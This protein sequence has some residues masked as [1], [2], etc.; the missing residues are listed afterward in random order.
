MGYQTKAL[1]RRWQHE[2]HV[3][4]ARAALAGAGFVGPLT[5]FK[6]G[7]IRKRSGW[8]IRNSNGALL[9]MFGTKRQAAQSYLAHRGLPWQ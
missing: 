8:Q 3:V 6:V 9:Q 4:V 2:G 1:K 7:R 5:K